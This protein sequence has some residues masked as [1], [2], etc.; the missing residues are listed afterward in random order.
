MLGHYWRCFVAGLPSCLSML[1]FCT[2]IPT[3]VL[4]MDCKEHAEADLF[5]AELSRLTMLASTFIISFL[6]QILG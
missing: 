2:D 3:F 6:K 1:L 5:K 4:I